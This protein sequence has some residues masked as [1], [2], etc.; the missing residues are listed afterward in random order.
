[1][2]GETDQELFQDAISSEA[3]AETPPATVE[4]PAETPPADTGG[5]QGRDP[6]TGQFT[7]KS[8]VPATG[9]KPATTAQP[10]GDRPATTEP[11]GGDH[12]VPLSE[13]LSER[14]RRQNAER[15]RDEARRYVEQL[16]RQVEALQRPREAPKPPDP[17]LDPQGHADFIARQQ[18]APLE[19]QLELQ[20]DGFS[21]MMAVEKYGEEPVAQAFSALE[22]AVRLDPAMR[23]QAQQIW[24]ASHPYGALM[25]W[26]RREQAMKEFG[27]DPAA[28]KARLRDEFLKDPEFRKAVVEAIKAET[29]PAGNGS[30][31]QSVTRLPPSLSRAPSAASPNG[32]GDL[33]P[34]TD[35]ELFREATRGP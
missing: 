28:Y 1:M 9:E 19:R 6:A 16:A 11:T 30:R 10:G 22:T 29:M 35:A 4:K 20:R 27:S 15:D 31:P 34:L 32:A 13:H 23:L 24:Q 18:T 12:R 3:P 33:V 26:H 25:S 5:K 17:W 8:S 2:A 14:E 7:G 21:R